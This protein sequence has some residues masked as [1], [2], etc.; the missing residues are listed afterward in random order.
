MMLIGL[1]ESW[2][3]TDSLVNDIKDAILALLGIKS[4]IKSPLIEVAYNVATGAENA[5]ADLQSSGY[6]IAGSDTIAGKTYSLVLVENG[7]AVA[8]NFGI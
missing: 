3:P 7:T 6:A 4:L 2:L 8:G 5:L 1:A